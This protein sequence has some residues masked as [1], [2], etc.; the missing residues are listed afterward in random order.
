[1]VTGADGMLGR[2]LMAELSQGHLPVPRAR[3]HYDVR[4]QASFARDLE[5]QRPDAVINCAAWTR[6][7]EAEDAPGLVMEI[8]GRAPGRMA[9][10]CARRGVLMVQISTDYVFD[11]RKSSPYAEDDEPGPVNAYGRSKLEAERAIQSELPGNHLV[12]RS[13]WMFGPG[14]RSFVRSMIERFRQGRRSFRVVDDQ[15][16]RPTYAPDLATMT[17]AC[18]EKGLR[19]IY[20]AC[21]SGETSWHHLAV[22]LFDITGLSGEVELIPVSSKELGAKAARPANSVLDTGKLENDAGIS[23]PHYGDALRRFL[24]GP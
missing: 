15:R 14:G 16:G 21:N 19:G 7:D 5:E 12:I 18:L 11:G 6:V 1:M 8:N 3:R 17:R 23:L 2:A 22:E 10:E 13:S 20:H 9:R 4:D 24:G